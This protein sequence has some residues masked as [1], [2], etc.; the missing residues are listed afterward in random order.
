MQVV[1]AEHAEQHR[2]AH[3]R[4]A[5]PRLGGGAEEEAHLLVGGGRNDAPVLL[6][7]LVGVEHLLLLDGRGEDVA[8]GFAAVVDDRRTGDDAVATGTRS[9]DSC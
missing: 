5:G 2:V 4:G 6:G 9:P 7:V 8:D 1:H 3:A